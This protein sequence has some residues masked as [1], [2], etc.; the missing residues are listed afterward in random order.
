M[1]PPI[2]GLYVPQSEGFTIF[3]IVAISKSMMS[4]A[5]IG[6]TEKNFKGADKKIEGTFLECSAFSPPFTHPSIVSSLFL[7][8]MSTFCFLFVPQE[9]LIFL[10]SNQLT[11]GLNLLH[12]TTLQ[13]LN[14]HAKKQQ[15]HK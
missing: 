5:G 7:G 2:F 3:R 4:S 10:H 15:Q 9:D 11:I 6:R 1:Y 12:T 8:V 13:A 14:K